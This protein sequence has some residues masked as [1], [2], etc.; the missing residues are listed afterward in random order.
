MTCDSVTLSH[1]ILSRALSLY[2]KS[3]KEK[4]ININNDLAVLLSHDSSTSSRVQVYHLSE[5][6]HSKVNLEH[7]PLVTFLVT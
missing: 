6:V 1:M 2:S 4:N 5:L 7:S 3:K